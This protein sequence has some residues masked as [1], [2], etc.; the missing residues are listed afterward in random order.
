MPSNLE[1]HYANRLMGETNDRQNASNSGNAEFAAGPSS[2]TREASVSRGNS[3]ADNWKNDGMN[4]A[5]AEMHGAKQSAGGT[6]RDIASL[7]D[8]AS[9]KDVTTVALNI[10]EDP[11]LSLSQSLSDKI[12]KN[13]SETQLLQVLVKNKTN[14]ILQVKSVNFKVV[15]DDKKQLRILLD[16]GDPAEAEKLRPQLEIFF[17]R[18]NRH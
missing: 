5:L 2:A 1:D 14:F 12:N 8:D 13:D 15:F 16:S 10:A 4:R 17:K 7:S 18:L 6:G 3:A 11:R 9:A